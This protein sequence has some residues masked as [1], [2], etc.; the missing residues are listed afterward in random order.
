MNQAAQ[1]GKDYFQLRGYQL[2][3]HSAW[4]EISLQAQ[5]TA[6]PGLVRRWLGSQ[7]LPK[8]ALGDY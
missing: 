7:Q 3:G 8:L 5:E 4:A 6:K 1:K 2:Q